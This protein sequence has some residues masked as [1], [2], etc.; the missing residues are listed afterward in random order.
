MTDPT[1]DNLELYVMDSN[2][3]NTTNKVARVSPAPLFLIPCMFQQSNVVTQALHC[4]IGD[5]DIGSDV[6]NFYHYSTQAKALDILFSLALM[7]PC[8]VSM[9]LFQCLLVFMIWLSLIV[10]AARPGCVPA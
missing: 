6:S 5:I 7:H 10:R 1:D 3:R 4:I 9:S 8:H 2:T